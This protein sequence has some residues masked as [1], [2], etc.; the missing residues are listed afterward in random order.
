MSDIKTE[1]KKRTKKSSNKVENGLNTV[2]NEKINTKKEKEIKED[3]LDIQFD[4]YL[5]KVGDSE[6]ITKV[7]GNQTDYLEDES[8][9]FF[10]SEKLSII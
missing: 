3:I 2:N 6:Y 9:D 7:F 5:T 8:L 1:K 10:Y 4:N